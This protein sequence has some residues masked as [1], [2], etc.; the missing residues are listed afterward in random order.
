MRQ[1]EELK[2]WL[3]VREVIL[4]KNFTVDRNLQ[5]LKS[6]VE[7]RILREADRIVDNL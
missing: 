5:V 6:E 7:Q 1:S 4:E 3:E 2:M